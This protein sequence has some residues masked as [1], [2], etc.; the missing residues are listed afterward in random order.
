MRRDFISKPVLRAG[1]ILTGQMTEM[2][3]VFGTH[4][5][6]RCDKWQQYLPV[7]DRHLS[8]FRGTAV[9]FL[10]IGVANGGSF[11]IWRR[12]LGEQACLHGL[13]ISKSEEATKCLGSVQAT[14]HIGDQKNKVLLRQI[15]A[16]MG[17]GIDVVIDDGSHVSTDQIATFQLLY[18]LLSP[19]G[20]YIC[21]DTHTSYFSSLRRPGTFVE[22]AK[23]KI[24]EI[25]S[26]YV[27]DSARMSDAFA[28]MTSSVLFYDSMVVFERAPAGKTEPRRIVVGR[29]P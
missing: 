19:D 4:E 24:D 9:R 23:Q 11:E 2:E 5:G 21:E 16:E 22:F 26:W 27:D 29:D 8:K 20:V 28:L 6:E 17:G 25:H 14:L 12:Y 7:Y 10:E 15:V 3:N 18:P 13:D 1:D